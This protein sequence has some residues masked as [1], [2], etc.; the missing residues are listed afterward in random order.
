MLALLR[1]EF[2]PPGPGMHDPADQKTDQKDKAKITASPITRAGCPSWHRPLC[3][4][5]FARQ[6]RASGGAPLVD[7]CFGD[8]AQE[9]VGVLLFLEIGLKQ[10][11]GVVLAQLSRPRR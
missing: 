10:H 6:Y 4:K 7:G 9:L 3:H 8:L 5:G 2:A 11:D 1:R